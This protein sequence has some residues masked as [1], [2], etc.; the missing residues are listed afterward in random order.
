MGL[1]LNQNQQ[2]RKSGLLLTIFGA[3]LCTLNFDTFWSGPCPSPDI[4]WTSHKGRSCGGGDPCDIYTQLSTCPP[5]CICTPST[6]FSLKMPYTSYLLHHLSPSLM[7]WHQR[8]IQV[9]RWET[10]VLFWVLVVSISSIIESGQFH[11]QSHSGKYLLPTVS[12]FY[13]LTLWHALFNHSFDKCLSTKRLLCC[14]KVISS[15]EEK[16]QERGEGSIGECWVVCRS[17]VTSRF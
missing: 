12:I 11:L 3:F 2:G 10:W 5:A 8:L 7:L 16:K 9:L 17:D 6:V 4:I 1:L 15:Q 13:Y 14:Y